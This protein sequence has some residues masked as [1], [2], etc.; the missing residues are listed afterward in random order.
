[1]KS[2]TSSVGA[3]RSRCPSARSTMASANAPNGVLSHSPSTIRVPEA[4][5]NPAMRPLKRRRREVRP[6]PVIRRRRSAAA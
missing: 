4:V 5:P 6:G 1:M 3:I 2:A